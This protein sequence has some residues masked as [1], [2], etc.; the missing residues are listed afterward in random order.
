[1]PGYMEGMKINRPVVRLDALDDADWLESRVPN[2]STKGPSM[3]HL[4]FRFITVVIALSLATALDA[5]VNASGHGAGSPTREPIDNPYL[6]QFY[7]DAIDLH[8]RELSDREQTASKHAQ[9]VAFPSAASFDAN[10][11]GKL[12][13]KEM[14]AWETAM[15]SVVEKSPAI[16]QRFDANLDG[17]LDQ[18]EWTVFWSA[19]TTTG[20]AKK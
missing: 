4:N 20:E 1:M 18:A 17:K 12:D 2:Q 15:R 13:E 19:L 11:D 9:T 14:L 3:N 6:R 16:L 10:H 8:A 5:Q 7:V